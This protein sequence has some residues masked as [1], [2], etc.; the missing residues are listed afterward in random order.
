M[1]FSDIRSEIPRTIFHVLGGVLLIVVAHLAPP[2]LNLVFL[3][4]TFIGAL[5][6]DLL[7][8]RVPA[9]GELMTRFF[10]VFMRSSERT[11][12]TGAPAFMG[13]VFLAYLLFPAA[14][15]LPAVVPLVVG[16]RAALLV[17]KSMGKLPMWG[18]T[19]EGSLACFLTSLLALFVLARQ[20]PELVPF[21]FHLLVGA[22]LV[23]AAAEALPRPF[24]DN[25]T[26]P[27][28]VGL[29]LSLVS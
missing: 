15:A 16:D 6:V 2:P 11:K 8:L 22:S 27:L 12:V 3:G 4:A 9:V 5:S 18:K 29:F 7:R 21:G 23:G 1:A 10:G 13:G 20:R 28:A 24:D 26:I 17:G 19:L 14:V 25:L